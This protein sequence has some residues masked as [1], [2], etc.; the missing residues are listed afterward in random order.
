MFTPRCGMLV[1]TV[2][3]MMFASAAAFAQDSSAFSSADC[4]ASFLGCGTSSA[5]AAAPLPILGGALWE[6][7]LIG[8]ALGSAGYVRYRRHR[9]N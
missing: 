4:N 7:G 5:A 3:W 6:L 1:A 8:L 2:A 9:K